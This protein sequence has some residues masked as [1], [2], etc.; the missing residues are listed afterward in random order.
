MTDPRPELKG[1]RL[2]SDILALCNHYKKSELKETMTALRIADCTFKITDEGG[3][4][5]KFNH[6]TLNEHL[7]KVAKEILKPHRIPLVNI[8][9]KVVKKHINLKEENW[10][11]ELPF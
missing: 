5:F 10:V 3:W 6:K 11:E 8:F 4:A 1:H 2:W 9:N 7:I